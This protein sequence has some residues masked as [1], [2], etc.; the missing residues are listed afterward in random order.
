M[1]NDVQ[2][3]DLCNWMGGGTISRGKESIKSPRP[4]KEYDEF[5][6]GYGEFQVASVCPRGMDVKQAVRVNSRSG[7]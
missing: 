3:S 2:I 4:C 5:N 6:F 1:K 7:G